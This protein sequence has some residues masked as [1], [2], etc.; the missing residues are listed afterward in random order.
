MKQTQRFTAVIKDEGDGFFALCPD[1]DIASQG[2]TV[3]AARENL[4]EAIQLFFEVADASEVQSRL[5][6]QL[7][8]TT[9]EVPVG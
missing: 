5:R 7:F 2:S 3:E 6:T 9:V 4:I 8:V 1:L